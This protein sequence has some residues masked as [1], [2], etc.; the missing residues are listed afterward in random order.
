METTPEQELAPLLYSLGE[1]QKEA[2][3]R[4]GMKAQAVLTIAQ[5]L[6]ETHKATTYPRTDCQY[7]PSSMLAEAGLVLNQVATSNPGLSAHCQ[8][9]IIA[10]NT[11]GFKNR[12]FND[13]QITAHHAIIPTM[14]PNVKLS[15]MSADEARIY[16]MVC[17]RY[18]A[19]FLGAH[20]FDKTVVHVECGGEKF[21]TSGKAVTSPGWKVLYPA[22]KD[23]S[24]GKPGKSSDEDHESESINLPVLSVGNDAINLSCEVVTKATKP[25]K[26][27]TE[28][29]LIEA[30]ES[31]D[32]EI[33]DPRMKQIMKNKEKAGI[34]TDATRSSIIEN[35]F[36]RDYLQAQG[37]ELV[38]SGRAIEFIE[39]L[40]KIAPELADPVLTAQWE[41]Q[42]TQI[43]H[44]ELRL[45]QFEGN[46]AKWL[47]QLTSSIRDQ[48]GSFTVGGSA[49]QGRSASQV[50]ASGKAAAKPNDAANNDRPCPKCSK[51]LKLRTGARGA[52]WGV[53]VTPNAS[54]HSLTMKVSR[55]RN[56]PNQKN[57]GMPR[58][59][60]KWLNQKPRRG[61]SVQI[62][63]KVN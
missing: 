3:R 20:R 7:L 36:K 54:I 32:K 30:M 62:V 31:I 33:D 26:R 42:L 12:V 47:K 14:N 40:E 16:D 1:L 61:R 17:R 45:E 18:V 8:T 19:L 53:R 63:K 28:G 48:K 22:S 25:P 11:Q 41:E 55:F 34:G 9:A 43:E 24:A 37:K 39:L 5:S 60:R 38:P 15:A 29:T 59:R 51:P 10:A 56:L 27:Y 4:F 46:L 50:K 6:Y 2:S 21:R 35:L 58:F 52:F 23:S 49:G 13:K 57:Q 44:G